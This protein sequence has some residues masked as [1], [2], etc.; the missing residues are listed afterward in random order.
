MSEQLA[1]FIV[2]CVYNA[3]LVVAVILI[4]FG[5]LWMTGQRWGLWS[6]LLMA[7]AASYT[8]SK[9]DSDDGE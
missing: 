2:V 4:T 1:S 3:F 6:L 8:K 7:L 9:K 5:G